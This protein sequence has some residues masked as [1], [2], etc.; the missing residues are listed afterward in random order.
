MPYE[1]SFDYR[2]DPSFDFS[3]DG[4]KWLNLVT[5]WGPGN[6]PGEIGNAPQYLVNI[7]PNLS[8]YVYLLN[9][10]Q[11]TKYKQSNRH[12]TLLKN[13]WNKI[14][15]IGENGY[16][17]LFINNKLLNEVAI[18]GTLRAFHL[19]DLY[20]E[21]ISLGSKIRRGEIQLKKLL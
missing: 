15:I 3:G 8:P 18:N 20:G 16:V 17:R 7:D 10:D 5:C 13:Q 12:L 6:K 19:G 4:S 1:V 9:D 21:S 11:S 14:R 2:L